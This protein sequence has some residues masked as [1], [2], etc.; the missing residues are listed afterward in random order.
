MHNE[1]ELIYFCSGSFYKSNEPFL[2]DAMING[3]VFT[4]NVFFLLLENLRY[5]V[6]WQDVKLQLPQIIFWYRNCWKCDILRF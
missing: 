6:K 3:I 5:V 1:W 2:T 4:L